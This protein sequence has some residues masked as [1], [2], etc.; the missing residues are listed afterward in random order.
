MFQYL[1]AA[2]FVLSSLLLTSVFV[3]TL[4]AELLAAY[5]HRDRL[6]GVNVFRL[7]DIPSRPPATPRVAHDFD[8][9][10]TADSVETEYLHREPLFDRTTSGILRVSSGADG[11]LLAQ[12]VTA[13]PI[14]TERWIGDVDGNGTDDVAFEDGCD[15]LVL[16]R[17]R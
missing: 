3:G 2:A 4:G 11:S 9:D 10:G 13:T 7:S 15:T 14:C 1:L 8:G 5:A 16:A 6:A 12:R 17:V